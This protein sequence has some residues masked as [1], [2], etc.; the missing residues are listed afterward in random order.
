[1]SLSTSNSPLAHAAT[2]SVALLSLGAAPTFTRLALSNGSVAPALA[3]C[4][5]LT[6]A[7][8]AHALLAA[9]LLPWGLVQTFRASLLL[10]SFLAL[11]WART[12]RS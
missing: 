4:W 8:G 6:V 9:V 2:L 12:L 7:F 10:P 1:M 5:R 11:R 3:S